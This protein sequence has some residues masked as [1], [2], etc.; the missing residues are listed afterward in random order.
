MSVNTTLALH[1][2]FSSVYEQSWLPHLPQ[3]LMCMYRVVMLA[4]SD[5]ANAAEWVTGLQFEPAFISVTQTGVHDCV[6]ARSLHPA[7]VL[8]VYLTALNCCS[9]TV[10]IF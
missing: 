1:E 4:P 7:V 3:C 6:H 9:Q 5:F 2:F 8:W 10:V